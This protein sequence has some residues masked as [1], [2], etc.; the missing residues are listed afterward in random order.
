MT[1]A[2]EPPPES[3]VLR[4]RDLLLI[5]II[6]LAAISLIALLAA[7]LV[8]VLE[9]P[10]RRGATLVVGTQ[11][12]L[13]AAQTIVLIGAVYLVAVRWRG[14]RWTD[15]G[16][17]PAPRRWYRRAIWITA[18]MLALAGGIN[19]LTQLFMAEA[20]VNPQFSLVA[21][22]GFSWFALLGMLFVVGLFIP[23]AEELL[24]RGVLYGWLRQRLGVPAA[25]VLSALLFSGVHRIVWLIPALA[26]IGVILALVYEKSGSLW[27]AIAV[28]AL[29]NSV[30]VVLVYLALSQG[31]PL[32]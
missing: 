24:F 3:P 16:L 31:V 20:P 7:P 29:F 23:F 11:L 14:L 28:H 12:L 17:R 9:S 13:L 30:G 21:P 26:V 22:V 18:L 10:E 1:T 6:V 19:L 8:G 4:G 2:P 27:P 32:S 5:L 25:A 15:L